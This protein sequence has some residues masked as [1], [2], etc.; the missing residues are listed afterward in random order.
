MIFG[1]VLFFLWHCLRSSFGN[2]YWC[3]MII[4]LRLLKQPFPQNTY[5]FGTD[6]K[7]R[8]CKKFRGNFTFMWLERAKS[9][10]YCVM[11]ELLWKLVWLLPFHRL[12]LYFNT[13]FWNMESSDNCSFYFFQVSLTTDYG[14]GLLLFSCIEIL[15]KVEK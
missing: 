7:V 9:K 2:R 3:L 13:H 14:K 11:I 4:L 6:D 10:F 5:W 1:S 8:S 12:I 15:A